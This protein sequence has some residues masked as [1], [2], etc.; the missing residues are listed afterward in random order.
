[1]SLHRSQ[2]R[3]F[4][5]IAKAASGALAAIAA[6]IIFI[7]MPFLADASASEPSAGP[8]ATP[9]A[10]DG[11]TP[12]PTEKFELDVA[13]YGGGLWAMGYKAES[14]PESTEP[15]E[16]PPISEEEAVVVAPPVDVARYLGAVVG[17]RNTYVMIAVG[18]SQHLLRPGQ[19]A[20]GIKVVSLGADHVIIEQAGVEKRL[21]IAPRTVDW[22]TNEPVRQAPV[23][24]AQQQP[25]GNI[26]GMSPEEMRL[27]MEAERAGRNGQGQPRPGT[28]G[29]RTQPPRPVKPEE[30]EEKEVGS[31]A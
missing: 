29:G 31:K 23:P 27:K 28:T 30:S 7:P 16:E 1:M 6:A 12:P 20:G 25:R 8:G 18:G 21:E 10:P 9:T 22:A 15:D 11:S 3:K 14:P 24:G 2:A 17:P 4:A 13:L 26:S 5:L 19:E